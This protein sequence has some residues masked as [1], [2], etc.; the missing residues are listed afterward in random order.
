M[1]HHLKRSGAVTNRSARHLRC[2]SNLPAIIGLQSREHRE[3]SN[4][5]RCRWGA[6]RKQR[7][8]QTMARFEMLDADMAALGGA[9]AGSDLFFALGMMYSTGRSVPPDL[10]A[11]HKWFN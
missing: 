6:D 8:G 3:A 4:K 10:V 1:L 7:Q 11:A 2:D 5:G 9:P